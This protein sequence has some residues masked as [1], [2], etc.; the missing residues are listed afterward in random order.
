MS[1]GIVP[2]SGFGAEVEGLGDLPLSPQ[3]G[4]AL[5]SALADHGILVARGLALS[6][7]DQVALTRVFGE[8]DIHPIESIRLPGVPEIIEFKADFADRLSPDDP[9]ADDVIGATGWH[10]DLTYTPEPSRGA[11]LYALEVPA[12]GGE[13]GFTDTGRV[14]QALP[15]DLKRRIAGLRVVHSFGDTM[16]GAGS[17]P[18]VEHPLVHAHPTT[19]EPVLN[20]SPMFAR[21]I[22]GWS[23]REGRA[24]LDELTAFATQERFTYFHAWAPHDIV[25]W[26]NWR[27]MHIATGH[28]KRFRRH[29]L[30]TT[31]QG[32]VR[33][34]A[35]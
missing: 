25:V 2:M 5:R 10:S 21:C 7:R 9:T 1:V 31:V 22:A 20:V 13:T 35:A 14:Y 17:F 34:L 8:P 19:G 27:T 3:D 28:P 24:L 33:L 30:R 12:R 15:Q 23:E 11:L 26:D 4:S 18:P 29:M 6:P 32:G 16:E